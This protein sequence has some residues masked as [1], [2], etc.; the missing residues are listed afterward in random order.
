MEF[1][2]IQIIALIVIAITIIKLSFMLFKRASFDS[3]VESYKS[4]IGK[5]PW[6]YFTM[7]LFISI[8]TLYFIRTNS[9]ISYTHIVAVAMFIS[10]LINAGLMGTNILQHYDFSKINWNMT[11]LYLLVWLFIMFKS[12]QEIFN[13]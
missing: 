12:L 11:G 1:N 7:Y 4:S 13:F 3:F 2:T 9:D 8:L 5:K 6:L 10:F